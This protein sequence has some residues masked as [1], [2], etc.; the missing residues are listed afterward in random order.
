VAWQAADALERDLLLN[1]AACSLQ[2]GDP[3]AAALCCDA[4]LAIDRG[5]GKAYYRRGLARRVPCHL[6]VSV[7]A[8][9]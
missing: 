7:H 9:C 1:C 5:C 2:Q 6:R 4:A 3:A 8:M